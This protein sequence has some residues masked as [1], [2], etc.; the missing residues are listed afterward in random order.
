MMLKK[1]NQSIVEPAV[2][3]PWPETQRI[4]QQLQFGLRHADK[5]GKHNVDGDE[6]RIPTVRSRSVN[7]IAGESAKM[8]IPPTPKVI[9]SEPPEKI[10]QVR[11]WNLRNPMPSH[12]GEVH[13]LYA[14]AVNMNFVF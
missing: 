1:N 13:V 2:D 3:Q 4:A 10:N 7:K 6:I 14:L 9:G 8:R 5:F 12:K 11:A